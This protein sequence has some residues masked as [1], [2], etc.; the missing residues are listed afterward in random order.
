MSD[1]KKYQT[2]NSSN[3][4]LF[5]IKITK[6]REM[7][8]TNRTRQRTVKF[9]TGLRE[10]QR[11]YN[12]EK[13]NKVVTLS[14]SFRQQFKYQSLTSQRILYNYYNSKD[15]SVFKRYLDSTTRLRISFEVK[16]NLISSETILYHHILLKKTDIFSNQFVNSTGPLITESVSSRRKCQT[17]ECI[18]AISSKPMLRKC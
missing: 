18:Y 6:K 16:I 7:I 11:K 10:N 13:D 1:C 9:I 8:K 3:H 12:K 14:K 5:F 15:Q 2:H 17:H 4:T